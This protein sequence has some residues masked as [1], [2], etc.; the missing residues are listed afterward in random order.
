MAY[1]VLGQ[2]SPAPLQLW[3][4]HWS[5]EPNGATGCKGHFERKGKPPVLGMACVFAGCSCTA[6]IIIERGNHHMLCVRRTLRVPVWLEAAAAPVTQAVGTE[7]T[8]P[9]LTSFPCSPTQSR[10]NIN[11]PF[12]RKSRLANTGSSVFVCWSGDF[13]T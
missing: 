5:L 12:L 6:G 1:T 2:I 3:Q 4:A 11:V 13:Q 8:S 7:E 9:S 10:A